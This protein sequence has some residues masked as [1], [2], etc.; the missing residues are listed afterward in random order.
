MFRGNDP[1]TRHAIDNG[2]YLPV[3]AESEKDGGRVPSSM[4]RAEKSK[5]YEER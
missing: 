1:N 4:Q 2:V 3:S 5:K